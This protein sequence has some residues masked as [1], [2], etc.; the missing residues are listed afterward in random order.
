MVAKKQINELDFLIFCKDLVDLSDKEIDEIGLSRDQLPGF[1]VKSS[2]MNK[3]PHM[4]VMLQGKSYLYTQ[5]ENPLTLV[6]LTSNGTYEAQLTQ[7]REKLLQTDLFHRFL[8]EE[9]LTVNRP[10]AWYQLNL[11]HNLNS[12]NCYTQSHQDH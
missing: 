9:R 5:Q 12:E 10:M 6:F 3:A 8:K 7:K 11:I 1:I 2:P 4:E